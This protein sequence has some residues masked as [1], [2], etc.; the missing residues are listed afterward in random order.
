MGLTRR[1]GALGSHV[2]GTEALGARLG[3]DVDRTPR[4][5]LDGDEAVGGS[6]GR[7][8]TVVTGHRAALCMGRWKENIQ[9]YSNWGSRL[10]S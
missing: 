3:A 4:L 7:C 2:R 1:S 8:A 5:A 9:A 10:E 6:T